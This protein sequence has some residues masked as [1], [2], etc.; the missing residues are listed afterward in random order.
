MTAMAVPAMIDT[1]QRSDLM[2]ARQHTS[3]AAE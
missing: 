3:V 2:P 1:M